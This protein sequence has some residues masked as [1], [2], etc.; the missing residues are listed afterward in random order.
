MTYSRKTRLGKTVP[1]AVALCAAG[2]AL[3]AA[4]AATQKLAG[5]NDTS[6]K[7]AALSQSG[8]PASES[9]VPGT[10]SS[11]TAKSGPGSVM[12]TLPRVTSRGVCG[13]GFDIQ[14]PSVTPED[15]SAYDNAPAASVELKKP[16]KGSV[17]VRFSSGV[18]APAAEDSVDV[19]LLAEC[20]GTGGYLDHCVTG[21]VRSGTP[22]GQGRRLASGPVD[23]TSASIHSTQWLYPELK[24]GVWKFVVRP[25]RNGG[26]DVTLHGRSLSV[27]AFKG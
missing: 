7:V 26:D 14:T 5:Q 3:S 4:S 12:P 19:V 18:R 2:L 13:A 16:C 21:E 1:Y 11:G 15:A 27:A 17:L 20:I 24:P 8:E 22:N 25:A 23:G 9:S 10:E 6:Q